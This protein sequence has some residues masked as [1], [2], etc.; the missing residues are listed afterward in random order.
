M[1]MCVMYE[2]VCPTYDC[3]KSL[4]YRYRVYHEGGGFLG[5]VSVCVMRGCVL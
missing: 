3:E 1:I 5:C 2:K 4:H